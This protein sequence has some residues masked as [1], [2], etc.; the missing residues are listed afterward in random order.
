MFNSNRRIN[1]KFN[2]IMVHIATEEQAKHEMRYVGCDDMGINIMSPKAIFKTIK[3]ENV[4]AKAANLL[5]QTFL[6]KGGEVAVARGCADLSIDSTDVLLCAT[7]KQYR[8][9][10]AQLK[11]QP[12]GLPQIAGSIENI[13]ETSW[14]FPERKY[15]WPHHE[16]SIRPGHT[17]V[18]GILNITPDSFS[19]G[20]KFNTLDSALRQAEKLIA[21]GA[22]IIDIG[23]ESTRPYGGAEFVSAEEEM[24]RLLPVLEKILALSSVPI[25]ID[26]YKAKVAEQ[27]LKL[28]AHMIND[29]W[30]LQHDENMAAV[31]A[32]YQV[33]VIIMH[34]QQQAIYER[35]IMSHIT[36][37]LRN[38]IV[39][40]TAAGICPDKFIIDP[41]IGFAKTSEQ[42]LQIMQQLQQ[43][44]SLDCPILLGTSRKRFIGEVLG[45]EVDERA[46]GTGATISLGITKGVNIVRV[47]DVKQMVRYARMTDAMMRGTVHG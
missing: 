39:I 7:L 6:A 4:P 42:N 36:E 41:G 34:N 5:K 47:H 2:P 29:V 21:E 45:L 19:D 46:E 28:G 24:E 30:G 9:A 10:L 43:L 1:M 12:W 27:A 37:F 8:L 3:L 35:N 14:K 33:P 25:S 31:I 38:S 11:L 26:T 22:E 16:L 32:K 17:V 44:K 40:G 13:L 18:M 23:A 20:G 15:V